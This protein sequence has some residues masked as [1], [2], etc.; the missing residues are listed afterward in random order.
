MEQ[1]KGLGAFKDE[2]PNKRQPHGERAK[3]I[4]SWW[5]QN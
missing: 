2:K 5:V 4:N 1:A 3:K